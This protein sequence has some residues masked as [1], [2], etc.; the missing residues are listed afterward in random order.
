LAKF[1]KEKGKHGID[2][3]A[4]KSS[5][6]E[7]VLPDAEQVGKAAEAATEKIAD[8]AKSVASEATEAVK[9]M[10]KDTDGEDPHDEL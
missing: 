7:D 2:A 1:V 3:Y 8:K 10:A 9:T 5:K 6:E 4:A